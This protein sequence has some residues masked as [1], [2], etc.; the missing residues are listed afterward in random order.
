MG[1]E[2]DR[3]AGADFVNC[4]G[5]DR[6]SNSLQLQLQPIKTGPDQLWLQL[7]PVATGPSC[8][9]LQICIR[10][11]HTL[12]HHLHTAEHTRLP[13]QAWLI[14][15]YW[16]S[17]IISC[18]H[19][20]MTTMMTCC[21]LPQP[22]HLL[23]R[24]WHDIDDAATTTYKVLLSSYLPQQQQWWLELINLSGFLSPFIPMLTLTTQQW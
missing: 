20:N 11:L 1:S 4:M 14:N 22:L 7:Q 5:Y 3:N 8:D 21:P 2:V 15:T 6:H 23:H 12:T 13:K 17:T 10:P 9:Q 18:S 16:S 24:H 19:D